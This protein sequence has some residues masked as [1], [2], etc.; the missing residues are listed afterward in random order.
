MAETYKILLFMKRRPGMTVEEFRDYYENVHAPLAMKHA[1]NLIH[2]VRRYIE[3]L[4]HAE[5]GTWD[6]PPF[7]VIT[8]IW[9]DDEAAFRSLVDVMTTSTMPRNIVEDEERLFDRSSFRIATVIERDTDLG[10]A[11]ESS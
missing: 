3:P 11:D 7:D 2:Y 1:S 6:D 10:H 8:E 4:P 5:T 9:Y